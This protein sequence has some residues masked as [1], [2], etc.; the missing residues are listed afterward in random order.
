MDTPL[1]EALTP[2][3]WGGGLEMHYS[4]IICGWKMRFTDQGGI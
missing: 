1:E 3:Q 2:T 4:E